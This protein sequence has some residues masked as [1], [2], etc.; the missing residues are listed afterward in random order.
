VN[1]I[2]YIPSYKR[3]SE[4]S[5]SVNKKRHTLRDGHLTALGNKEM[6]IFLADAIKTL[7]LEKDMF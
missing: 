3:H 5:K 1:H 2:N 6:S 4:L 7:L